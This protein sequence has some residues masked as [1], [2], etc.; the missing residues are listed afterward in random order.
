MWG[1]VAACLVINAQVVAERD[2]HLRTAAEPVHTVRQRD[3][4][5]LRQLEDGFRA[6]RPPERITRRLWVIVISDG[7]TSLAAMRA[8]ATAVRRY[9][10]A[11]L[12]SRAAD[13]DHPDEPGNWARV[14]RRGHLPDVRRTGSV[15]DA[16]RVRRI[17]TGIGADDAQAHCMSARRPGPARPGP[18]LERRPWVVYCIEGQ[19]P[20]ASLGWRFVGGSP[21]EPSA[22]A[23]PNPGFPTRRSRRPLDEGDRPRGRRHQR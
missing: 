17:R 8:A 6:G 4:T 14:S 22:T 20:A 15:R 23:N 18:R 11:R 9:R 5:Q 16:S 19:R 12:V 10:P 21:P 2:T 3:L 7:L 1:A 13:R